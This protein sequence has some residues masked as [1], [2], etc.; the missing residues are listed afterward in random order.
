MVRTRTWLLVGAALLFGALLCPLGSPDGASALAALSGDVAV[1]WSFLASAWAWLALL[2]AGAAV[3]S[4]LLEPREGEVRRGLALAAPLAGA[5]SLLLALIARS[6]ADPGLGV[7]PGDPLMG[8]LFGLPPSVFTAFVAPGL[9]LVGRR[10]SDLRGRSLAAFGALL[11][12]ILGAAPVVSGAA[13]QLPFLS[14]IARLVSGAPESGSDSRGP[15]GALFMLLSLGFGVGTIVVLIRPKVAST[16]TLHALALGALFLLPAWHLT[17]GAPWTTGLCCALSELAAGV[18]IAACIAALSESS[19]PS[20]E[21]TTATAIEAFLLAVLT[22]AWASLKLHGLGYSTTDEGIYFYAA[23]AWSEGTWPYRD[24]FFS[25]PPI[26]I[27]VPAI[28]F[29]V[30]GF[31]HTLAKAI[32]AAASIGTSL[33]LW[34]IGRKHFGRPAGVLAFAL[35]LF[36]GEVLKASTNLTGINLATFFLTLGLAEALERRSLRAGLWLG[37][38]ASTGLYAVAGFL[39]LVVLALFAPRRGSNVRAPWWKTRDA[40]L[41]AGGFLAVFGGI[42]LVFLLLGGDRYVAGVFTYHVLKAPKDPAL[43]PM[44]EGPYALVYNFFLLLQG[45]DLRV[46]LYHHAAHYWFALF[47]PVAALLAS[48]FLARSDSERVSRPLW[49]PLGWWPAMPGARRPDGVSMLLFFVALGTMGELGMFK[50]R[51]DFYFTILMPSLSLLAAYVLVTAAQLGAS[52][53]HAV[54][55]TRAA[56]HWGVAI[57]AFA[58]LSLWVP[59]GLWANGTAYPEEIEAKGSSKGPGEVLTF[60]WTPAAVSPALGEVAHALFWS[61]TRTRGNLETGIRHY[62]WSKKRWFSTAQEIARYVADHTTPDDTIT[63]ASDYAPL[64][65]I[66]SGRRLSGQQVDTNAKVFKTRIVPEDVFWETACTDRVAYVVAA[67]MSYF[68]PQDLPKRAMV[69]GNFHLERQFSD[70]YLKHWKPL[71]IQLWRRNVDPPADI[72]ASGTRPANRPATSP[73]KSK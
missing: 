31:H 13:S 72:C 37:V 50:E 48:R 64:I 39:T 43:R 36:A 51:Y 17:R 44:S 55:N 60:D 49:N 4:A 67:E 45:R 25:H 14:A 2:G 32:P 65:A 69:T 57:A 20:T 71:D 15:I 19:T 62:L 8:S 29:T 70:P 16:R 10:A 35:F 53:L 5:T 56:P 38:A 54:G 59:L 61:D 28:A 3:A 68:A 40:A 24:F 63:G 27:L 41:L 33:L 26:H 52:S 12:V 9:V 1:R 47:A 58:V 22:F 21:D 42:N 7:Y 73:T 6:K 46:S 18:A 23:K 30:F 66:L 34:R 11:L